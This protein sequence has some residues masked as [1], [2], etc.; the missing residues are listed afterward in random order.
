MGMDKKTLLNILKRETVML[1]DTLCEIYTPLV[2]RNEPKIE[3]NPYC[4]RTAGMCYQDQNL[5]QLSYKFFVAKTQYRDYMLD[6]ILPHEVAHQADWFLYGESEKTC[7]HGVHWCEIMV[8]LGLEP[9]PFHNMEIPR[10]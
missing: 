3:L 4:W 6:V 1:W 8:Q 5:I 10:K 7:G 9:N 2:H